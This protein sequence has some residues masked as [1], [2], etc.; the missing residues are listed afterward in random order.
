MISLL[1][2]ESRKIVLFWTVKFNLEEEYSNV[3][4]YDGD[5]YNF[6]FFYYFI[7]KWFVD[8]QFSNFI[9]IDTLVYG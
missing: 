9:L 2:I 4:Y 3:K 6:S 1:L 5:D 7:P 8:F